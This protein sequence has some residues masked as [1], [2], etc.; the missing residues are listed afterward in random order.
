MEESINRLV[1]AVENLNSISFGDI[2]AI[3]S[4]LASWITIVF[5]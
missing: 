3:L 1:V 4:L 2:I 5:L